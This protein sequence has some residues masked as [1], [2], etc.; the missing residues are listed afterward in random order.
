MNVF[1][2]IKWFWEMNAKR[3]EKHAYTTTKI[4]CVGAK[5]MFFNVFYNFS[6]LLA[7]DFFS[8]IFFVFDF[9]PLRTFFKN[10]NF[11]SLSPTVWRH[12]NEDAFVRFILSL[13]IFVL[14]D[15]KK[16]FFVFSSTVWLWHSNEN[17][18]SP[19]LTHTSRSN[20]SCWASAIQSIMKWP[21]R[22]GEQSEAYAYV[23]SFK[24]TLCL[25]CLYLGGFFF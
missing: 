21:W 2:L 9:E 18:W 3:E 19:A 13:H 4:Y 1:V 8:V 6:W 25:K 20:V 16:W 5:W 12:E 17:D 14:F 10:F 7:R 11:I 22:S 15:R 24:W 23:E